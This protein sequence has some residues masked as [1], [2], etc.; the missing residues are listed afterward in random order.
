MG[1]SGSEAIHNKNNT[2]HV[3]KGEEKV[4]NFSG[5]TPSNFLISLFIENKYSV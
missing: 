1:S 2:V 4:D 5:P 3:Q